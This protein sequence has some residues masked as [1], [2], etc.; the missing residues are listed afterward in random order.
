MQY[1]HCTIIPSEWVEIGPLVFHEAISKGSDVIAA[2]IG[3]CKVL[4]ELYSAKSNLFTAGNIESLQYAIGNFKYSGITLPIITQSEN[5]KM[6]ES[7]YRQMV[8]V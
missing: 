1:V 6:V 5:Y 8:T 4:A 3:G 2:D 7:Q